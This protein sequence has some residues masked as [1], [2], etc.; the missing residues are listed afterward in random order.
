MVRYIKS[1]ESLNKAPAIKYVCEYNGDLSDYYETQEQALE[2]AKQLV[3]DEYDDYDERELDE[4][5]CDDY[6]C[7]DIYIYQDLESVNREELVNYLADYLEDI[8]IT[9]YTYYKRFVD[10]I[11]DI[12]K[13]VYDLPDFQID[14]LDTES[15]ELA[16]QMCEI[17]ESRLGSSDEDYDDEEEYGEW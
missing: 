17:L 2:Y 9:E 15:Y 8:Y 11:V 7:L 16:Y 1:S 13:T 5:D 12:L 3:L 6:S 4:W 14:E 10:D